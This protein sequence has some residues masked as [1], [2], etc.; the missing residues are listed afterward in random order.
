M[1]VR[2]SDGQSVNEISIYVDEDQP[3]KNSF[4]ERFLKIRR[5]KLLNKIYVRKLITYG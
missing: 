3:Y 5:L 2:P 4:V 1:S